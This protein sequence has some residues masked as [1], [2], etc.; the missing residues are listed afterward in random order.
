[1]NNTRRLLIVDDDPDHLLVAKLILGRRGYEVHTLKSCDELINKIRVLQ[2]DLIF[3]DHTMP[4]MTGVEATRLIKSDA[5]CGHIPVIY[6]SSREDIK[7]LAA[8]AGADDW[9][10]KP[11]K[12]D[13]LVSIA[14]KFG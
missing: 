4:L 8:Q 12:L 5:K 13:D 6:F 11:F 10:S 9:L 1:M 7:A 2:P 14:E 3:M